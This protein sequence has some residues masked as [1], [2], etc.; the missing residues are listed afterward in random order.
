[1]NPRG[2]APPAADPVKAPPLRGNSPRPP[3]WRPAGGHWRNLW[4]AV[5]AWMLPLTGTAAAPALLRFPLARGPLVLESPAAPDQH[6]EA[7]GEQAGLWGSLA[8][9]VEAWVYPF[10]LLDGGTLFVA[11]ADGSFTELS[12]LATRQTATPHM[13]Q[14][15]H[16]GP[17]WRLSATWFVPRSQ[18]GLLLLLDLDSRHDLELVLRFRPGAHAPQ[19]GTTARVLLGGGAAGI[20]G[21]RPQPPAGDADAKPMGDRA[22]DRGWRRP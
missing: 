18:P 21:A 13:A 14:I 4:L 2:P 9:G 8:R 16:A 7:L 11:T 3:S 6:L 22:S 10:K 12:P 1:M 5:V 19:S 20:G 15:E 17:G